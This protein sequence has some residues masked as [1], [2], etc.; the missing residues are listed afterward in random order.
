MKRYLVCLV[1]LFLLFGAYCETFLS[2]GN[3]LS[4]QY[5]DNGQHCNTDSV[6]PLTHQRFSLKD[7]IV[8]PAPESFN[9]SIKHKLTR[10][11][12]LIVGVIAESQQIPSVNRIPYDDTVLRGG[13]GK[14][15]LIGGLIGIAATGILIGAMNQDGWSVSS[16]DTITVLL[17]GAVNG[18][19]IGGLAGFG[20]QRKRQ[21]ALNRRQRSLP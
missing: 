17:W 1:G 3:T 13:V 18:A 19:G 15:A 4:P 6:T 7:G 12:F 11:P 9:L 21:R 16:G 2:I 5:A 8:A 14:G 20:R 10:Y